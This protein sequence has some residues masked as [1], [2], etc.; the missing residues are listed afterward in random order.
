MKCAFTSVSLVLILMLA[1]VLGPVR[2]A[3]AQ[4]DYGGGMDTAARSAGV[5]L[6]MV[7]FSFNPAK[8]PDAAFRLSD[9]AI[10]VYYARQGFM[11][12]LARSSGTDARGRDLTLVEGSVDA[13]GDVRPFDRAPRTRLDVFFPI[14]LYGNYRK[15]TLQEGEVEGTVFDVSVLA[16]GVGAGLGIR[17]GGSRLVLRSRP[18]IGVA[19]RSLSTET[20]S[21]TGYMVNAMW[22]FPDIRSGLGA[23]AGWGYR[24]QRWLLDASA[25]MTEGGSQ[26]IAYRGSM[27]A[28]LVGLTF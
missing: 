10:G 21:S 11:G 6:G 14:G 9:P 19:S 1:A 25:I 12:H 24:W 20:G 18:F 15:V 4:F 27:H 13:W 16:L 22:V 23:Y 3:Q 28:M 7:D 2:T 17:L 8:A 5:L 26:H